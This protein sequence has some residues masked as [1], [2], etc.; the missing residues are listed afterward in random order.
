MNLSSMRTVVCIVASYLI[1]FVC[2]TLG[3]ISHMDT[4][5]GG[6]VDGWRV[7]QGKTSA[8]YKHDWE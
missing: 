6:L 4:C 1:C 8:N 3:L 7:L 2:Q 5:S